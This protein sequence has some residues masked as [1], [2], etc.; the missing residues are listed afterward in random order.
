[1]I[2]KDSVLLR[3]CFWGI[4]RENTSQCGM[5][6]VRVWGRS[7]DSHI[8]FGR[9]EPPSVGGKR[10]CGAEPSMF[11]DFLNFLMKLTSF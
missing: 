8:F 4:C 3:Q 11:G 7:L 6:D 1:L 9:A 5:T 2:P 10:I